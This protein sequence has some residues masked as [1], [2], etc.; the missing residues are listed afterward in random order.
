MNIRADEF[1]APCYHTGC[2]VNR[3]WELEN[4]EVLAWGA[5]ISG[6]I[7]GAVIN[8]GDFDYLI[9]DPIHDNIG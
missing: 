5:D 8:A 7:L 2:I 6:P 4:M 1:G 3:N 9:L